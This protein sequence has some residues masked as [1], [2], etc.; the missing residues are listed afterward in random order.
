MDRKYSFYSNTTRDLTYGKSFRNSSTLTSDNNTFIG[1]YSFFLTLN[2]SNS[3]L[4]SITYSKF[5][6]VRIKLFVCN[7]LN[8]VHCTSFLSKIYNQQSCKNKYAAD[9][10]FQT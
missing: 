4:Y 9:C 6:N 1:L 2:D 3:N 7:F 10:F 8:F 5:W